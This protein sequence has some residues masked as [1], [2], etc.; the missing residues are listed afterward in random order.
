MEKAV[1]GTVAIDYQPSGLVWRLTG[2]AH[3]TLERALDEP[4]EPD[5]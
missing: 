2:P 3:T 1:Q 5:R 4:D